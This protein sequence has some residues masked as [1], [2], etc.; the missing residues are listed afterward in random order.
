MDSIPL[1]VIEAALRGNKKNFYSLMERYL[2]N[3]LGN[4]DLA[5]DEVAKI[6]QQSL[7]CL[8]NKKFLLIRW[9]IMPNHVHLLICPIDGYP[10]S[11]SIKE[12]KSF[13]A[14]MINKYLNRKGDFWARDYFDTFIRDEEHFNN[15]IRYIDNNPVKAKRTNDPLAWRWGSQGFHESNQKS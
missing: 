14:N 7:F 13:T 8:D 3:H 2:D 15:C 5:K 9:V 11:K 12:L 1:H 4:L 6:V 10:I